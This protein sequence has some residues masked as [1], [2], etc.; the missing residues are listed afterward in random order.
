MS[1][2]SDKTQLLHGLLEFRSGLASELIGGD[3]RNALR[4]LTV[5][6]A[7]PAYVGGVV[8]GEGY[9]RRCGGKTAA[10]LRSFIASPTRHFF[11]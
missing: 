1:A 6:A 5:G 3:Q 7:E 9:G 11:A 2:C 10:V 4:F 8:L